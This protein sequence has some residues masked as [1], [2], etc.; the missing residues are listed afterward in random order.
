MTACVPTIWGNWI[1][2][3]QV[4]NAEN[5]RTAP[6]HLILMLLLFLH[7][8]TS[9]AAVATSI[10]LGRDYG[11]ACV[12]CCHED[13]LVAFHPYCAFTSD[14][15]MVTRIDSQDFAHYEIYCRKHDPSSQRVSGDGGDERGA[16]TSDDV[17][18]KGGESKGLI[19]TNPNRYAL[20]LS[21]P[22]TLRHDSPLN[23]LE[24]TA[25][26]DHGRRGSI[27]PQRRR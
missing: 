16:T 17:V 22:C 19:V 1:L 20:N 15:S 2:I 7:N 5:V 6:F 18:L 27:L 4:Y 3:E 14:H 23:G 13:C 26:K 24:D 21:S 10:L 12:Q 11:G 8:S 9:S 25:V